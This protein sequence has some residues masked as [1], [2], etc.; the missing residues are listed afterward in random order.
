MTGELEQTGD[1]PKGL[2]MIEATDPRFMI[3]N[4]TADPV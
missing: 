3:E 1:F 4:E 2:V